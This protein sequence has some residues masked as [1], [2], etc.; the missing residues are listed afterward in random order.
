MCRRVSPT[1]TNQPGYNT[2]AEIPGSGSKAAEIVMLGAHMDSWHA[3]T[4]ASDNG[5]GVAVMMEAMR[6]LKAVGVKPSARSAWPC[7]AV[8]SR[9]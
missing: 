9:A 4:G 7:G 6:I 8:R 5:A 1:T 3:G 2:V